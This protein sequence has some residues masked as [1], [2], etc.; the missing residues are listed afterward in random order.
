MTVYIVIE[1]GECGEN[2]RIRGVFRKKSDAEKEAYKDKDV[3][4]NVIEREVK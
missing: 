1:V 3:W 4:C 2:P